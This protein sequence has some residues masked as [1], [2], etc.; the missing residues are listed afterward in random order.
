MNEMVTGQDIL[1]MDLMQRAVTSGADVVV[2]EKLMGLQERYEYNKARKAFDAAIAAFKADVPPIIKDRLVDFTTNR[3]R[4]RYKLCGHGRRSPT[5]STSR[6]AR[7]AC[8]IAGAPCPPRPR[9]SP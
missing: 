7:S 3:G 1:P 6:S 9:A 4:T 2:L 5:R 8:P